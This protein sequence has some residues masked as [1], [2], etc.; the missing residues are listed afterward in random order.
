MD[1][2]I[3]ADGEMRAG[4]YWWKPANGSAALINYAPTSSSTGF[5]MLLA[6]AFTAI[7]MQINSIQVAM[8]MGAIMASLNDYFENI[9]P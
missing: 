7:N 8:R 5:Y 6:K 2:L 3:G 1:V 9:R 4:R